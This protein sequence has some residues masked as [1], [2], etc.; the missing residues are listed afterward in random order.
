M[1]KYEMLYEDKIEMDSHTL[2]RIRAL[3]DFGN[4][5]TGDI[6]GYIERKENLSQEGTCWIYDNAGVYGDAWIYGNA[7]VYGNA[8]VCGNAWVYGN[9]KVY[10]NAWVCGNAWVYGNA[11]VF[12]DAKVYGNAWVYGNAK[13]FDDAKVYGNAWVCGNA[14]IYD[15]VKVCGGAKVYGNAWVYGNAKVYDSVKVCGGAKISKS[16]DILCITP[17]GSRNDV[18]TFFKTKDNNICV[19]CGCFT[20]TIDRFLEA[21]NKTHGENKHAKA[22]KLACELAR[23]QIDLEDVRNERNII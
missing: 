7:K 1:N 17:I 12:D 10:G 15:S 13:V 23:V 3:K 9:A 8:W 4:V 19:K 11:K 22:Y 16:N 18:T 21:V 14:L 6:G 20:G 5:K 2:Y